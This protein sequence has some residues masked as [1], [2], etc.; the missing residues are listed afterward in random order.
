MGSVVDLSAGARRDD[1]TAAVGNEMLL[2]GG[3][4]YHTAPL[5]SDVAMLLPVMVSTRK[6]CS[7]LSVFLIHAFSVCRTNSSSLA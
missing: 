5:S 6:R 7:R 2:S 4:I 3:A 1:G